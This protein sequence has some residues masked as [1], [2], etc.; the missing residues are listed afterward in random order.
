M[1]INKQTHE[2]YA[3]RFGDVN[4]NSPTGSYKNKTDSSTN[5]GSFLEQDWANDWY[6]GLNGAFLAN[7]HDA[8][9]GEPTG[10][11]NPF[12]ENGT[13]TLNESVDNAQ[14]SQV[15][16]AWYKKTQDVADGRIA[17]KQLE[18]KIAELEILAN[19]CYIH[20]YSADN[21]FSPSFDDYI[22]FENK[23]NLS[24]SD[25]PSFINSNITINSDEITFSV[26]GRYSILLNIFANSTGESFATTGTTTEFYIN[27][28]IKQTI[29]GSESYFAAK[30]AEISSSYGQSTP[31]GVINPSGISPSK[32]I[33]VNENDVLKIHTTLPNLSA[34]LFNIHR[35]GKVPS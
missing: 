17:A 8:S 27:G 35:I 3:G 1:T 13:V 7:V 22:D 4:D 6:D 11:T 10:Y 21:G 14:S 31:N 25:D 15:Y 26:G 9:T 23:N 19:G 2:G 12:N 28:S 5:D 34:M 33:D 16:N 20:W 32:I 30:G 18:E 29:S 24:A